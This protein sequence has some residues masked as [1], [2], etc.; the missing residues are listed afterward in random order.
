MQSA[1]DLAIC[2]C[3]CLL[4]A[5]QLASTHLSLFS[6]DS[7]NVWQTAQCQRYCGHRMATVGQYLLPGCVTKAQLVEAELACALNHANTTQPNALTICNAQSAN[8]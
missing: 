8:V 4:T 5:A 1:R 2:H 6:P 3:S 7:L